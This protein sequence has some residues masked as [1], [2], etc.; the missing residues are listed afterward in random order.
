MAHL[1]KDRYVDETLAKKL[2]DE[3]AT[4]I[5]RLRKAVARLR[6]ADL[7]ITNDEELRKVS[8][9]DVDE[10]I[11]KAISDYRAEAKRMLLADDL[12]DE[13]LRRYELCR[14]ELKGH[15][16][17]VKDILSKYDT[18]HIK[19]SSDGRAFFDEKELKT[20]LTAKATH[21]Y[22]EIDKGLY[23]RL[24]AVADAMNDLIRYEKDHQLT[25]VFEKEANDPYNGIFGIF[26][27]EKKEYSISRERYDRMCSAGFAKQ[28]EM[29]PEEIRRAEHYL[30]TGSYD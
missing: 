13:A 17:T 10:R 1:L 23:Q 18:V 24:G 16:K 14:T 2:S 12:L 7:K 19:F 26:D 11:N 29:T 9:K 15:V 6:W 20:C 3:A 27:R 21:V 22:S 4:D 8:D 28:H 25:H 5:E 30:R